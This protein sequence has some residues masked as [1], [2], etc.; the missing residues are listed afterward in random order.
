MQLG[1]SAAEANIKAYQSAA[2]LRVEA[3]KGGAMVAAQLSS[4]IFAG[5]SVQAHLSA[6]AQA[7][8]TYS[9]QESVQETYP[10]KAV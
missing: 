3:A 5:V 8:K 6:G 1:L 9:G 2:A 7:S 10:H 4:G